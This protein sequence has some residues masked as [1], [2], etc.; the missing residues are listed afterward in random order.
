MFESHNQA[1]DELLRGP[2]QV[3]AEPIE[4]LHEAHRA[5]G[6]SLA[7]LAVELG[8]VERRELLSAVGRSL[9]W[10]CADELPAT[11][12]SELCAAVP[13]R[14]ARRLGVFPL[15]AQGHNL[16][17][18]AVD[19]FNH[20]LAEDL[21]FALERD[22]QLVV[23]DPTAILHLI[24]QCYGEDDTTL[25]EVLREFEAGAP[26]GG[27]NGLSQDDLAALAGRP[28][29]VRFVDVVLSQAVRAHASDVH[30]E[31]F[32]HE[33]KIR[34]RVDGAL[35][36]MAPPPKALA[37][38]VT[39]RLKV[40]ADLNI[41]ERRV[42]QDGRIRLVV[43]DHPVDLRVSTLPTQF[44]ESVVLRVLD[45]SAVHLELGELGMPE[46]VLRGITGT[47]RRPNGILVVTGPTGSGKTTTLYSALR[48]INSTEL[49][50][51]TAEDP[52]EYEIEGIMQV[53][54]NPG[55]G[56]SFAAA[57]RS[58]LRQDPDVILVGEI[59]DLETAQMAIQASLTGHLV[60]STLH[61]N[62]AVGAIARLLDLGV[63]P[64]LLASTLEGV[65]A[66]RLVRRVCVRC[67]TQRVPSREL[68]AQLG[69]FENE[70]LCAAGPGCAECGGTGYRG[71]RGIFEWLRITEGLREMIVAG[72]PSQDLR[73]QAVAGGMRTLREDGLRALQAG[74]TTIEE[75]VRYT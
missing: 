67:R 72:A 69:G 2:L 55:I 50:L 38:P 71:R 21:T 58:F 53:P 15:R 30:F 52:V 10:R 16:E 22:V 56:L 25:E 51:L 24:R 61:T 43:D 31:P 26:L 9:G 57:L 1:I 14:T 17:L 39:S 36:E 28:P 66:Q 44:G 63:E 48:A 73:R 74:V 33:F 23:G 42:P 37:L 34:Y 46:D 35:Y 68:G 7:D 13:A 70:P 59:R 5:T 32:E 40:L 8:V 47:I 20:R 11:I 4:A 29:V 54:V 62:D 64:F 3:P 60:L 19:P 75:I 6:K 49:K 12:S 41:A 18:L 45:R 65:L 27:T